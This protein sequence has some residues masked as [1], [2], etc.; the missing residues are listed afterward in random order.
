MYSP[1]LLSSVLMISSTLHNSEISIKLIDFMRAFQSIY[2]RC[3]LL[4]ELE[5]YSIHEENGIKY[6][7]NDN[8]LTLSYGENNV[9]IFEKRSNLKKIMDSFSTQI[10]H[11]ILKKNFN[12]MRNKRTVLTFFD[13]LVEIFLKE[14]KPMSFFVQQL[15]HIFKKQAF[16]DT[17][18]KVKPLPSFVQKFINNNVDSSEFVIFYQL[19]ATKLS[20]HL[21]SCYNVEHIDGFMTNYNLN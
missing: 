16:P 6:A 20:I 18:L 4:C 1:R 14:K 15:G 11:E 19:F 7:F 13:K 12:Q 8:K 5:S 17:Q 21:N 2:L 10:L 3:I 9:C